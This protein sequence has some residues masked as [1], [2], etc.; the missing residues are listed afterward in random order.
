MR[1]DISTRERNRRHTE[2]VDI[3]KYYCTEAFSSNKSFS[4]K[5]IELL[6]NIV[7]NIP[8]D[9]CNKIFSEI[10]VSFDFVP[11]LQQ[12]YA[13]ITS[14]KYSFKQEREKVECFY[15]NGTGF[16]DAE[17]KYE[18]HNRVVFRCNCKN[19]DHAS[20]SVLRWTDEEESWWRRVLDITAVDDYLERT[21][22]LIEETDIEIEECWFT[23]ERFK[24][25]GKWATARTVKFDLPRTYME[26]LGRYVDPN[27]VS[28]YKDRF[29]EY[30]KDKRYKG[31]SFNDILKEME[32]DL[33]KDPLHKS[34]YS[35]HLKRDI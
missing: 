34:R 19:G 24:P 23:E 7:M 29:D 3:I 30:K 1:E 13:I 11:S 14:D 32:R 20:E 26:Y 9:I 5:K 28:K 8:V 16:C 27:R 6:A 35:S 17:S 2:R 25:A 22:Q 12:C 21:G 33:R 4:E 31:K 15:C 10:S 18:E